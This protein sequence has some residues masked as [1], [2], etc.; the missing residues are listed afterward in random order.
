MI[1]LD[2]IFKRDENYYLQMFLKDCKY[3]K[4]VVRDIT[5]DFENS[6]DDSDEE[7]IKVKY[8]YVF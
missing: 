2:S 1:L 6:F 3:I 8:Q 5:D 7:Y 4:K